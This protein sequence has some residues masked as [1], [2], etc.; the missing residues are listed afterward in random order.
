M[1]EIYPAAVYFTKP[2]ARIKVVNVSVR[3]A[4]SGAS[5]DAPD[6]FDRFTNQVLIGERRRSGPTFRGYSALVLERR[7]W[8][9]RD[10]EFDALMAKATSL[11]AIDKS[12]VSDGKW[13]WQRAIDFFKIKYHVEGVLSPSPYIPKQNRINAFRNKLAKS[14]IKRESAF[15]KALVLKGNKDGTLEVSRAVETSFARLYRRGVIPANEPEWKVL[16]R[17]VHSLIPNPRH[18]SRLLFDPNTQEIY[19]LFVAGYVG[20]P[21]RIF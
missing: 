13:A 18:D 4:P 8:I 1:L 5:A 17:G 15:S 7:D 16:K 12:L 6:E 11:W 2:N 21:H 9:G 20:Y 19:W 3:D 10:P 14:P